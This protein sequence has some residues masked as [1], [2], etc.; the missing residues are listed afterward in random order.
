MK[1]TTK[2]EGIEMTR[3]DEVKERKNEKEDKN[4]EKWKQLEGIK[5][6]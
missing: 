3:Y 2:K 5:L 1:K 6:V 4:T